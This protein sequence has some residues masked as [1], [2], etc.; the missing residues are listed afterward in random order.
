MFGIN[1]TL[2]SMVE[3]VWTVAAW[4]KKCQKYAYKGFLG[5]PPALTIATNHLSWFITWK[6]KT[7]NGMEM[8]QSFFNKLRMAWKWGRALLTF[9]LYFY[10]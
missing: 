4:G 5:N 8:G 6:K 2:Q 3:V 7:K 10:F 1:P 9:E